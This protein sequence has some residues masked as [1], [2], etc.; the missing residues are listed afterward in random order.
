M[1]AN[2]QLRISS[3]RIGKYKVNQLNLLVNVS[4]KKLVNKFKR[5]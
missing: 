5:S 4:S 1:S 3:F 2:D